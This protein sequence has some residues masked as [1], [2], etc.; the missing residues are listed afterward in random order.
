[1][2][3]ADASPAECEKLHEEIEAVKDFVDE[4]V[5]LAVMAAVA[6]V[7]DF[8]NIT[9]DDIEQYVERAIETINGLGQQY[10]NQSGIQEE[11]TN[12][13][14]ASKESTETLANAAAALAGLSPSMVQTREYIEKVVKE[15]AEKV[16]AELDKAAEIVL[17]HM[18][19]LSTG[20]KTTV[21]NSV[22]SAAG[23]YST[24]KSAVGSAGSSVSGTSSALTTVRNA[25]NTAAQAVKDAQAVRASTGQGAG[26]AQAQEY[27]NLINGLLTSAQNA[28]NS[29]VAAEAARQAAAAAA[30][31]KQASTPSYSYNDDYYYY[32]GGSTTGGTSSSGSVKQSVE[33]VNTASGPKQIDPPVTNSGGNNGN[34]GGSSVSS[35]SNG[36]NT[37]G[38]L[39]V[40]VD[41]NREV[42]APSS[43]WTANTTPTTTTKTTTVSMG[44]IKDEALNSGKTTAKVIEESKPSPNPVKVDAPPKAT[45]TKTSIGVIKT[46]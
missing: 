3:L 22:N 42:A 33:V 17:R 1:M 13:L 18:L 32:G 39:W 4:K 24:A 14:N 9:M 6:V 29:A 43:N 19:A 11:L 16:P 46:M 38:L 15:S 8:P 20:E 21:T 41:P 5:K 37:G 26:L 7:K 36:V 30:A 25:Y 23:A 12:A 34:S 40:D 45:T 31:A 28:Y 27:L 10:P 2:S 35:K 44:I